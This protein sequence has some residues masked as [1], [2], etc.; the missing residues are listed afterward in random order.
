[1][2]LWNIVIVLYGKYYIKSK[3]PRFDRAILRLHTTISYNILYYKY[4]KPHFDSELVCLH[5]TIS[6]NILY[7]MYDKPYFNRAILRLHTIYK[8]ITY[9]KSILKYEGLKSVFT[10]IYI[11]CFRDLHIYSISNANNNFR[12]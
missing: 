11:W 12:Y 10:Y 2:H 7:C 4:D 1:M 3:V 6:Y 5:T 9:P 8:S